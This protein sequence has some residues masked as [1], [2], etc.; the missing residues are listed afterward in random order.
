MLNALTRNL[1][2]S[3]SPFGPASPPF[4][5]LAAAPTAVLDPGAQLGRD[6]THAAPGEALH[7]E[8]AVL[9]AVVDPACG[10]TSRSKTSNKQWRRARNTAATIAYPP[11]RQGRR[12]T[13]A[14]VIQGDVEHGLWQR[15]P[16]ASGV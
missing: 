15:W 8:R 10:P 13:F 11:T 4:V 2:M 14:I 12:R 3:V 5:L 9:D 1:D 6:E 16:A 7:G